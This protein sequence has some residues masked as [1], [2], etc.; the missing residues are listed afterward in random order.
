VLLS[1]E[2]DA[3][4]VKPLLL[5]TQHAGFSFACQLW[6]IE[7]YHA[8]YGLLWSW[9]E[10]LVLAAVKIIPLGQ[11]AGQRLIFELAGAIPSVIEKSMQLEDDDI[12]VSS[13]AMSI[14]SS[15]HE[16]QYTRL[17]RS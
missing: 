15:R 17:F 10:N 13:M 4:E 16:T 14:A 8:L 1:L 5:Q 11:S 2:K 6:H 7:D 3:L 9:L 12:G